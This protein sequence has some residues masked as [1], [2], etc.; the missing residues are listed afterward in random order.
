MSSIINDPAL[1]S[2]AKNK[3]VFYNSFEN[4]RSVIK[5]MFKH[6]NKWSPLHPVTKMDE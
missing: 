2:L 5:Q 4:D 6:I 1:K 3:I